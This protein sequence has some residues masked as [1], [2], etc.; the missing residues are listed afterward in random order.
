MPCGGCNSQCLALIAAIAAALHSV[1]PSLMPSIL[2]QGVASH[3]Q[4]TS[5]I[6]GL[7]RNNSLCTAFSTYLAA[8][9]HPAAACRQ[10]LK[11]TELPAGLGI[12]CESTHASL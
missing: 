2:L 10:T 3:I 4:P 11:L 9:R 12:R 1:T 7:H 8:L 5:Y 6:Q